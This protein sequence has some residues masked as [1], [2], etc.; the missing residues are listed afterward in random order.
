MYLNGHRFSAI[1]KL[2]RQYW[3]GK[4]FHSVKLFINNIKQKQLIL[5]FVS[6][7]KCKLYNSD[8]LM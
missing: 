2:T 1:K 7:R 8:D 5:I 6:R 4:Y 3:P